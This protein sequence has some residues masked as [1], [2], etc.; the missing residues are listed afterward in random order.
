MIE[1]HCTDG[2]QCE[3]DEHSEC[4][5][6][7]DVEGV[8]QCGDDEGSSMTE[9]KWHEQTLQNVPGDFGTLLWQCGDRAT[10]QGGTSRC[11]PLQNQTKENPKFRKKIKKLIN[12]KNKIN[13]IK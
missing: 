6:V 12:K 4:G 2:G 13:K 9:H 8:E 7:G 3:P 11:T 5:D 1:Q 10:S